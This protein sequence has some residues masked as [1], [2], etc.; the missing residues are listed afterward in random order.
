MREVE[1]V[2]EQEL[3][4]LAFQGEELRPIYG[5][6]PQNRLSSPTPFLVQCPVDLT[7][8]VPI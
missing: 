1:G 8:E 3:T 5:K 6:R 4:A 2:I 7:G